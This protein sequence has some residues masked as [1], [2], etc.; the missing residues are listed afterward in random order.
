MQIFKYILIM[1][2]CYLPYCK[3]FAARP[4]LKV[5]VN[6]TSC[7]GKTDGTIIID[8]LGY[9]SGKFQIAL[10]DSTSKQLFGFDNGTKIPFELKNLKEGVFTVL[11]S[12]EGKTEKRNIRIMSPETLKANIIT[13]KELKGKGTSLSATLQANP[14]GGN[15]PY[16]IIWSDNTG[17]QTG[18]IAKELPQGIYRCTID[19]SKHCGPV[20]AT[21]FLYDDEIKKYNEKAKHN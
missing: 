16:A 8:L 14:S 4:E 1:L 18:Y 6:P 2:L 13:I 11:Y 5:T 17:K 12:W 19:D 20:T 9:S 21:F 3:S 15:Q 10:M 7:S